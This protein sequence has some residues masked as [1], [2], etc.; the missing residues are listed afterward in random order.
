MFGNKVFAYELQ[1]LG[2][3]SFLSTL[4]GPTPDFAKNWILMDDD[5]PYLFEYWLTAEVMTNPE[6][7]FV[8]EMMLDMWSNFIIHGNPTPDGSLGFTWDEVDG[9]DINY[10]A[11]TTS[12]TMKTVDT[13]VREFWRK[14]PTKAHQILYQ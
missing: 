1:H 2:K 6:D 8:R 9:Q 4:F 11:I 12:P 13:T 14:M 10:L 7:L 3:F 5:M